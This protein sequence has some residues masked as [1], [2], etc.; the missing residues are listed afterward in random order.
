MPETMR[1]ARNFRAMPETLISVAT[2][3]NNYPNRIINNCRLVID[4]Y[5]K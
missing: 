2:K 1:N 5:L 4:P 3:T